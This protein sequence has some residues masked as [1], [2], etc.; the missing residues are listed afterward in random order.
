MSINDVASKS[1]G[2][3]SKRSLAWAGLAAFLGCVACCALPLL[4]AT[5]AG[6]LVAARIAKL[7]IPGAELAVGV[8]VFAS[9]LAVITVRARAKRRRAGSGSCAVDGSCVGPGRGRP[10]ASSRG[11][12]CLP[13]ASSS[14][15]VYRSPSPRP[16]EPIACTFD[17]SDTRAVQAHMDEYRAAFTHLIATERFP[18]GF[19]WRFRAQPGLD[20]R[21]RSQAEREHACCSFLAFE[22]ST[23]GQEIIW[24][25]RAD[26]R[27]ASVLEELSRL[28]ERLREEPRPGHD[29]VLLEREARRAG[30]AFT[31][32]KGCNR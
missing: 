16:D 27:A 26:E 30:L 19:R 7:A 12:G 29:L 31:A 9:A 1:E 11:C 28:P 24:D 5:G 13:T 23:D 32:D 8:V 17:V 4:A 22:L 10:V 6:G 14:D 2:V 3:L 20:A 21:L 25:I 18:G 15:S